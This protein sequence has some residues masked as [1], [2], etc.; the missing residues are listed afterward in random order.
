MNDKQV[1]NLLKIFYGIATLMVLT[2]AYFK[3]QHYS[4]GG[5]ILIIGFIMG[6]IVTS[7]DITRLKKRNKY[8]EEK[9]KEKE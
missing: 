6:S 4:N 5:T 7:F 2:G 3:I 1:N 9:L 8:L